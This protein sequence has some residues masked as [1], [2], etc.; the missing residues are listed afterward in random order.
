MPFSD[1]SYIMYFYNSLNLQKVPE[2]DMLRLSLPTDWKA[3]IRHIG[4]RV[5]FTDCSNKPKDIDTDNDIHEKANIFI[6]VT[7]IYLCKEGLFWKKT[8]PS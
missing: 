8:S 3:C 7:N 1:T 6:L 4:I 5:E 2:P